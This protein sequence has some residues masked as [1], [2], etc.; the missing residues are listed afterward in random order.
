MSKIYS[1]TRVLFA[2]AAIAVLVPAISS[3]TQ[4]VKAQDAPAAGRGA[5]AGGGRGGAA[6]PGPRSEGDR[7]LIN[8]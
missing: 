1:Y 3:L 7:A 5:A 6:A 8:P 4:S 2:F